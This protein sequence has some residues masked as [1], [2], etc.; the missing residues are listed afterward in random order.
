VSLLPEDDPLEAAAIEEFR[1]L[2]GAPTFESIA[3][4]LP[5]YREA[6]SV[7]QVLREI[8]KAVE[9]RSVTVLVVVDGTDD[10]TSAIARA[11]GAYVCA[12][13]RQAGQGGGQGAALRLGYRLAIAQG[14]SFLVSLDADGQYDPGEMSALLAPLF[15]GEADFVSGSRRLGR[16]ETTDRVRSLGVDVFARVLTT[17][18]RQKV[19]DPAFGLRAMTAQVASAVKLQQPQYQAAELLL[20]AALRGFRIRERPATMRKRTKSKSR[21]GGNLVYGYRFSRAILATWWRDRH[22]R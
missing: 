7:G 12:T 18:T 13:G 5:A 19:T 3:V 14:A 16:D 6:G 2:N 15:A 11:L 20:G 8:P 1:R 4:I 9:G 17:L 22:L 10:G 21:K